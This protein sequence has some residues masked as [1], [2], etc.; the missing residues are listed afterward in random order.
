MA[1]A[2][3]RL[4]WMFLMELQRQCRFTLLAVSEIHNA[5]HESDGTR[6]PTDMTQFWY[7]IQGLLGAVGNVSKILWPPAKRCQPRGS[8]LRALLSVA[9]TSLLEPRTFRNH[10][11]H[12]DERLEAWFDQVGRQGMA[13]SCIGPTGEFGGLNSSH[14]L[15]NYA[16]DTQTMWFRGDAYHLIPVLDEVQF[17]LKRVSQELDKPIPW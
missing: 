11:E 2:M 15:R 8:R 7:N 5:M 16:T 13:D 1:N 6:K 3:Q 12:F 14:Y 9:D 17:L 4:D 10:F